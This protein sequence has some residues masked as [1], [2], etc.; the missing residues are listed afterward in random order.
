MLRGEDRTVNNAPG[1]TIYKKPAEAGSDEAACDAAGLEGTTA[2]ASSGRDINV[3][4]SLP[5]TGAFASGWG[6]DDV[7]ADKSDGS[8][9]WSSLGSFAHLKPSPTL[10]S[11][12]P[13]SPAP[14]RDAGPRR[15]ARG[16]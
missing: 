2:Q 12:A 6:G 8:A 1:W 4:K 10:S 15:G 11:P 9:R 16:S 5:L 13:H 14:R 7:Y 3:L